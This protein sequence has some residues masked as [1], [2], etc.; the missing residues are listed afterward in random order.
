MRTSHL[1]VALLLTSAAYV[2]TLATSAGAAPVTTDPASA[3]TLAAACGSGPGPGPAVPLNL[4]LIPSKPVVGHQSVVGVGDDDGCGE[5]DDH[6][7]H[8]SDDGEGVGGD[9]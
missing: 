9:D 6:G 8:G 1:I 5:D 7:G 3:D 2:G 4:D